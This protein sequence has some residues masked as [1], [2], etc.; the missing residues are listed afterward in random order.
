MRARI[1]AVIDHTLLKPEATASDI[2]K[3]CQEARQYSFASVCVNPFWVPLVAAELACSAVKVCTVIGFP[4]GATTTETKLAEADVA[5]RAGATE[6]DMVL[7]I[8]ALRSGDQETVKL[9]IQ[10]LAK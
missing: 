10:A 9:D 6:L 3:V 5:L 1:A 2:R 7:N 8:G 4:L